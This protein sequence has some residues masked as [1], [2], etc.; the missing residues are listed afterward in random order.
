MRFKSTA[1]YCWWKESCTSWYDKYPI[2]YT[3]LYIPG[4]CL[5]FLNHQQHVSWSSPARPSQRCWSCSLP[6]TISRFTLE[7]WIS[8]YWP[9]LGIP[10][11]SWYASGNKKA[12]KHFL[13]WSPIKPNNFK[14]LILDFH[15]GKLWLW[16]CYLF[17]PFPLKPNFTVK[18]S[19]LK[20]ALWM[21]TS[22]AMLSRLPGCNFRGSS[23]NWWRKS[24][25]S[26]ICSWP[27]QILL[28]CLVCSKER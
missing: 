21:K 10:G 12:L 14:S 22:I 2:I 6:S 18:L 7:P 1:W 25:V 13:N 28:H 20:R 24:K 19:R 8:R 3:V 9:Q 5:G 17:Y 26:E 4:G 27:F 11:I 16:W 15:F 23:G